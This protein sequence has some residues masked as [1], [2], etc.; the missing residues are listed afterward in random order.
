MVAIMLKKQVGD[1]GQSNA[2][3]FL[4]LSIVVVVV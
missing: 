2:L 1:V 4:I 3:G